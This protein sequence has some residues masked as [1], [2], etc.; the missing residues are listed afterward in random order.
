MVV[1]TVWVLYWLIC[2]EF[3]VTSLEDGNRYFPKHSVAL[4]FVTMEKVVTSIGDAH[5]EESF[6]ALHLIRRLSD[7]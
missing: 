2:L 7:V 3:I 5:Y 4:C 1:D 6:S